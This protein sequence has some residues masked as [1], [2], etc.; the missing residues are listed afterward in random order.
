[1]KSG[2]TGPPVALVLGVRRSVS[3]AIGASIVAVAI[4]GVVSTSRLGG[5]APRGRVEGVVIISI[6][7]LRADALDTDARTG[8]VR[9]PALEEFSREA[10]TFTGALAPASWTAPSVASMMTGLNTL[11]HGV[12]EP[13]DGTRLPAGLSTLATTLRAAGWSTA[14]STGGGWASTAAGMNLGF[15]QWNESLDDDAPSLAIER[16]NESRRPGR[17]FFL[18]LH[19]YVAHDPYGGKDGTRESQAAGRH[20]A[21]VAE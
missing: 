5:S 10:T 11:Q 2:R 16:W 14:A 9:L 4:L 17:P 21:E 8:A 12:I 19:T 1:M 13:L 7:T 15:E 6:D 3:I 18:W 20:D